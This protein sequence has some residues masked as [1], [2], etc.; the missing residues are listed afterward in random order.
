MI[1]HIVQVTKIDPYFFSLKLFLFWGALSLSSELEST[2]IFCS[3]SVKFMGFFFYRRFY[4]SC[5]YINSP[6]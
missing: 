5:N 2:F 4:L 1:I 3:S 6:D